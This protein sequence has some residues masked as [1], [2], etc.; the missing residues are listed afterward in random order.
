[1]SSNV[2]KEAVDDH[3]RTYFYNPITNKTSWTRPADSTGKWKT[4]YTDDGKPYYHNV[5]TGETTWD[6]PTDLENT[7]PSEQQAADDIDNGDEYPA[8]VS[9]EDIEAEEDEPEKEKELAKQDIKN[10][11]LIE[12]AHFESFK[13]AENAFVEMLRKNGVD[14]TWSFQKVMSTFIKEPLYWAIPDTLDRQKLYEEYLVQKLK[15]DMSNKSAIINNFEKNFIDVLQ[16]YEKEGNLNFHTRWVTVKQLL[17]KEENPIFKNSVLSD[18]QVSEIFYKFTSELKQEHDSRVQKEKE[19]ALKELKAYLTQ[20]NP[21][22]VEK[23]SD[24]TQLYETLMVDPRFKANKHFII[25]NKL[26]IL[27][28][29]RNE[30]HPLLLSNLKSE[31]AAVQKR[32]YRSDRKARQNFKD[33]L[34][35]KVT[36]NANTLFKDVFPIME[37]E[38][39]FIDLCGRNG[40][41]ALDLFWDVVDEKYQLM[42]LKNNMIDDLLMTLHKQDSNEFDYNKSLATKKDFINTLLRAKMEKMLTFD[43]NDFNL[44]E[45]DP[46]LSAIYDNLKRRQDL[47]RE[48]AKTRIVKGIKTL[49]ESLAHWISD[50][51]GNSEKI[52]IFDDDTDLPDIVCIKKSANLANFSLTSKNKDYNNILHPFLIDSDIYKKLEESIMSPELEKSVSLSSVV[53]SSIEIFISLLNGDRKTDSN[54]TGRKRERSESSNIDNKRQKHDS[55]SGRQTDTGKNPVLLNY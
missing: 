41:N 18:D 34:L 47:N 2:W 20:I 3:G 14:S 28:L 29:Y 48:R 30:I 21:E 16:R 50:N 12:P 51:Y 54:L 10:R 13:D 43:F 40:S 9:G 4:Y 17:I 11:E 36:I 6:I 55:T 49:T 24:W 39:S 46:E 5:E 35:N 33:F 32:N 45:D 19:Q 27:E 26:D 53:E 22:L 8:E 38:D 52:K 42:K 44:S 37:N 15:E 1:M 7:A 23:C 31:I 25:L